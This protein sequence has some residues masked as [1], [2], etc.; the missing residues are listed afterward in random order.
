MLYVVHDLG[1][2]L[3]VKTL[4]QAHLIILATFRKQVLVGSALDDLS[5]R[6]HNNAVSIFNGAQAMSNC[7]SGSAAFR[8]LKRSLND[9]L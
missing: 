6:E 3:P 5:S 4:P 9:F 8:C 2:Y 7:D 1:W